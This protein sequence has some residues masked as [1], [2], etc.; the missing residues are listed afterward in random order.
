[1]LIPNPYIPA[2]LYPILVTEMTKIT[3]NGVPE[4]AFEEL[5]RMHRELIE[6]WAQNVFDEN[7]HN[8]VR[9]VLN[10]TA[11]CLNMPADLDLVQSV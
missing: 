7:A 5:V 9:A 11:M 4:K 1:M 6:E 3:Y 8:R 10:I 2:S